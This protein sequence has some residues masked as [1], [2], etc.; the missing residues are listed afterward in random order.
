[1]AINL[2]QCIEILQSGNWCSLRFITADTNKG[3]G[4][5]IIE[6]AKC[7]I[8][9]NKPVNIP[10][11]AAEPSAVTGNHGKDPNH[12]LNFTRNVELQNNTI[13]KVHPILITHI[14]NT[15]VL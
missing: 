2:R 8:A 3:T 1:M 9:R 12:N 4:G 13:R 11:I 14:N 15:P 6:L 7:R 10:S 5:K